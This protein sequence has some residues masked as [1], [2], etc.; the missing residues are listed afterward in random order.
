[1]PQ[2]IAVR[3]EFPRFILDQTRS[4]IASVPV[5]SGSVVTMSV[6]SRS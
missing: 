5:I 3:A 1:M 4:L 2:S 6:Q